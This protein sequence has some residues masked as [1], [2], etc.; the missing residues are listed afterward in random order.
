MLKSFINKLLRRHQTTLIQRA[1]SLETSQCFAFSYH[2]SRHTQSVS[3]SV[4]RQHSKY[5]RLDCQHSRPVINRWLEGNQT[6]L[7]PVTTSTST[8]Q[9]EEMQALSSE[10]K[11]NQ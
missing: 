7:A 9:T 1:T 3:Q 10:S 5:W 8:R 6:Q 2:L 4:G 11:D